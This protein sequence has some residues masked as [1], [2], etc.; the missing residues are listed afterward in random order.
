MVFQGGTRS[1]QAS[2]FHLE[3]SGC[4]LNYCMTGRIRHIFNDK[5]VSTDTNIH[6]GH[7]QT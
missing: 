2:D 3:T 6:I 7:I 1:N 5:K 4:I